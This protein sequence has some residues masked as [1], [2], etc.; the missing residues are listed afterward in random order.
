VG[1]H[2]HQN[3][4]FKVVCLVVPQSD[5]E[6][7]SKLYVCCVGVH[8]EPSRGVLQIEVGIPMPTKATTFDCT[9][10]VKI[11]MLV[12]RFELFFWLERFAKPMDI[13]SIGCPLKTCFAEI[14]L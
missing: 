13:C 10:R 14:M 7:Y 2:A 3:E 5:E 11:H 4:Y 12:K 8:G 1:S 6:T 9:A